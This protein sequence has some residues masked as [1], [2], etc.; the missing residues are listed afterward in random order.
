MKQLK[1]IKLDKRENNLFKWG[2]A[3]GQL[4][5]EMREPTAEHEIPGQYTGAEKESKWILQL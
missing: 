5:L 2:E 4:A 1:A 3:Q